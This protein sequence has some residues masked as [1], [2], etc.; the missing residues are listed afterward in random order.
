MADAAQIEMTK[1]QIV[2][3]L[4]GEMSPAVYQLLSPMTLAEF[5]DL[6]R[7]ARSKIFYFDGQQIVDRASLFDRVASTMQF[8]EYFGHNWDA[9]ED[10]LTDLF[11]EDTVDRQVIILDRL[12]NFEIDDP[13]QWSML[14]AICKSTVEYWQDTATPM[15]ILIGS[16]LPQLMQASLPSI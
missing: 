16:N 13:Y 8:P 7:D 11:Y 3:M 4:A 14:L 9:L 15:Y 12:D 5:E 1:A 10:C 2:R 6:N